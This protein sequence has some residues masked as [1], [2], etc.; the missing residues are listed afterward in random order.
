MA[1]STTDTP[2]WDP[3]NPATLETLTNEQ[4]QAIILQFM[5]VLKGSGASGGLGA[6]G[7]AGMMDPKQQL[8]MMKALAG[9]PSSGYV[10]NP[11]GSSA[12]M[13][14]SLPSGG[15]VQWLGG[16]PPGY[17]DKTAQKLS[18]SAIAGNV[19]LGD[20]PLMSGIGGLL[21]ALFGGGK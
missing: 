7:G 18:K 13:Q 19:V 4:L 14:S 1:S 3:N 15:P 9:R 20:N 16:M 12:M 10:D 6:L 2:Q 5:D 17:D 11:L 8:A 21:K